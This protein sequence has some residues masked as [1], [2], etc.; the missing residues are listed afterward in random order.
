MKKPEF[1]AAFKMFIKCHRQSRVRIYV[2]IYVCMYVYK[3]LFVV[4]AISCYLIFLQL[5]H[6]FL[7][8]RGASKNFNK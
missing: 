8:I 5:V 1:V 2:C 7:N 3:K 4:T 6:P